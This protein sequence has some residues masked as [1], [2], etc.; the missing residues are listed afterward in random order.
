MQPAVLAPCSIALVN[1]V[2][3]LVMLP[4]LACPLG[5]CVLLVL[6]FSNAS[7]VIC[8]LPFPQGG[9]AGP[10]VLGYLHDRL[11][12]P[13]PMGSNTCTSSW[14]WGTVIIASCYSLLTL[15]MGTAYSRLGLANNQG[16]RG[17][18]R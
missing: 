6:P 14:G 11:G 18:D 3:N 12:P 7:L 17:R 10:V 16:R 4:Q 9:F 2:G 5:D 8:S 1:S 13:C 15:A